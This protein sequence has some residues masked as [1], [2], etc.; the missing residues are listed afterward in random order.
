[1]S[2]VLTL[3]SIALAA[4]GLPRGHALAAFKARQV[5]ID[6]VNE[7]P[8]SVYHLGPTD[9][10]EAITRVLAAYVDTLRKAG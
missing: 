6:W 7:L 10:E 1:M 5:L 9:A 4:N 3:P 8:E 2:Q